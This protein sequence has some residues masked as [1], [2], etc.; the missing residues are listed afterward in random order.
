MAVSYPDAIGNYVAT[1]KRFVTRG[2]QYVGY[3]EPA[4]ISAGQVTHLYLF[5]QNNVNEPITANLKINVPQSW[6]FLRGSRDLLAIEEPKLEVKLAAGEAGRLTLP[7]ATTEH[8][9]SGKHTLTIEVKVNS[10]RRADRVRPPK[11]KSKL[12]KGL[13]DNP[14]GLNLVSSLGATY[15]E[16]PVKKASFELEVVGQ[17][18]PAT[19][20]PQLKHTYESIWLAEEATLFN[21]AVQELNLRR[22]QL[23]KEIN[24]E[25]LYINL[26]GETTL[27]FADAGLPLRIGEAIVLAKILTYSCEYFLSDPNRRNGLLVP[28]WEQA[29]R[30]EVDTTHGL[31]IICSVGYYHLLRFSVAISFGL[32]RKTFG[33]PCWSL[34]ER[35]AVANHIAESIE[36]AQSLDQ[37]FLYLP[38]LMAGTRIASRLKLK[39]EDV[40]HTLTLL[41]QARAARTDLFADKDMAQAKEIY[42]HI[43]KEAL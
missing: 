31:D 42:D 18:Q 26:F 21:R 8:T 17:P 32:I 12:G 5:L 19:E 43:L 37:E 10:K 14:V 9:V 38:L 16:E 3:F 41:K 40:G 35:Q 33:D 27:R 23:R 11:S 28:I 4:Q 24:V 2:V 22:V 7:V 34:K 20:T 36:T 29:L 15:V 6:G 13:I 25:S 30:E 39:D 1:P